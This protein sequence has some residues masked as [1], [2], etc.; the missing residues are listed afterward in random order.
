MWVNS[1]EAAAILGVNLRKLQRCVV[2]AQNSCQKILAIDT[3]YFLYSYTD[4][5]GRG[6]KILQIWIDDENSNIKK[7]NINESGLSA[8]DS[9]VNTNSD[10]RTDSD[11]GV[12]ARYDERFCLEN[13]RD[14]EFGGDKNVCVC[15]QDSKK[16]AVKNETKAPINIKIKDLEN[17][18]KLKAVTEL[19]ACPKGMSKTLW[20]KGVSQI[21]KSFEIHRKKG[22][23]W[24]VREAV[25]AYDAGALIIEGNLSQK[26]AGS[27]AHDGARRYGSNTHWAEFSILASK[28]LSVETAKQLK[29]KA[30]SVA[31]VRCVLASIDSTHGG[32]TT[33]RNTRKFQ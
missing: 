27:F 28:P 14:R 20:G 29:A 1:K 5:V 26:Y 6:G 25:K 16:L 4:G 23:A 21:K 24:A 22:T 13:V 33:L 11:G 2:K 19:N 7:E 8:M 32:A 17:M 3:K 12:D 31:P 30:L 10:S 9:V 18:N 15:A